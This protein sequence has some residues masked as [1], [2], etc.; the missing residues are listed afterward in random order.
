VDQIGGQL[1][2]ELRRRRAAK[3]SRLP[4]PRATLLIVVWVLALAF[5]AGNADPP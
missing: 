4:S 5:A 1:P 2:D 3:P